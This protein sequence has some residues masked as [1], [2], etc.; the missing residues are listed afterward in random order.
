M[1]PGAQ[2]K[3]LTR[4]PLASVQHSGGKGSNQ[5]GPS[6]NGAAC[7]KTWLGPS[8]KWDVIT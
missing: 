4:G 5:A 8:Y 1:Q 7:I 2:H 3:D 6:T